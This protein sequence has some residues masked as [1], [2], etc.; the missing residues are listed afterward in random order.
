M[1]KICPYCAHEFDV[2]DEAAERPVECPE[3]GGKVF[4][5][6]QREESFAVENEV[7]PGIKVGQRLGDYEIEGRLGAGGMAVVLRAKQLA[8]NRPVALKILPEHFAENPVFVSRF[9]AEAAVL[10][11]LDHPNIVGVIDRG[12]QDGNYYIVMSLIEGGSLKERLGERQHLSPHESLRIMEQVC[13]GL[14]YAHGKGVIHRDIKP[15][16]IM[17]SPDGRVRIA[18]FGLAHLAAEEGGMDLT[19]S[20]QAMG[21][22]KYMAP[23]QLTDPKTVDARADIYAMGVTLYEMLTGLAPMGAFRMPSEV[24]PNIDVRL[25]DTITKAMQTDPAG[26]FQTVPE[27]LADLKAISS[28]A[29]VTAEQAEQEEVAAA[30]SAISVLLACRA[31]G[32]E[33]RPEAHACEKCGADLSDLFEP[34]HECGMENRLDVPNCR[35]CGTDLGLRRAQKRGRTE[36]RQLRAMQLRKE[37]KYDEAIGVLE[38]IVATRGREYEQVRES[39]QKWIEK[40]AANRDR[41]YE[42]VYNAGERFVAEGRRHH[43][44]RLWEQLP[45]DYRDVR[46]RIEEVRAEVEHA[47][48][49]AREGSELS[50]KGDWQA[51]L[52]RWQEAARLMPLDESLRNRIRETKNR[53]GNRALIREFMKE[54]DRCQSH[55]NMSEALALCQRVLELDP[56]HAGAREMVEELRARRDESTDVA[57]DTGLVIQPPV[58]FEPREPA[59]APVKLFL[60]IAGIGILGLVMLL[61]FG[62]VGGSREEDAAAKEQYARAEQLRDEGNYTA[63]VAQYARVTSKHAGSRWAEMAEVEI[64]DL[65]DRLRRANSLCRK[66]ESAL[67]NGEPEE[68]IKAYAQV[69]ADPKLR[70]DPAIR[71]RAESGRAKARKTA[72]EFLIG[73][74]KAAE[75][76]GEWKK[77]LG[78]YKDADDRYGIAKQKHIAAAI[79][80]AEKQT[81]LLAQALEAMKKAQEK[82]EWRAALEAAERA[83]KIS[84]CGRDELLERMHAIAGKIEP[85]KDMV[86][87]GRG[88][89]I[90]GADDGDKDEKPKREVLI[91]NL[92]HIDVYEVSNAGYAEFLKATKIKPPPHWRGPTPPKGREQH[93]VVNV[94]WEEARAYARAR[95]KELPTEAQ[96]ERAA[97]G[98]KGRLYSWGEVFDRRR[99]VLGFDS[100]PVGTCG[101]DKSTVGG[102][103]PDSDKACFDM[104][105]NVAEW[106]A[107]A[108]GARRVVKGASWVGLEKGRLTRPVVGGRG[109][110][111]LLDRRR[112]Q[113]AAV[114][115]PRDIRMTLL[116]RSGGLDLANIQVEKWRPRIR[117]WASSKFPVPKGAPIGR[118]KW[119]AKRKVRVEVDFSTGCTFLQFVKQRPLTMRYRDPFGME[120]CMEKARERPRTRRGLP[121]HEGEPPEDREAPVA[122]RELRLAPRGA[123][124]MTG[125]PDRRYLNV[126]FRCVKVIWRAPKPQTP[127]PQTGK[128]AAGPS[129]ANP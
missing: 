94:T 124:R 76:R 52:E 68:A 56:K 121:A 109:V 33:S 86:R 39:A 14:A 26:R 19:R 92:F 84:A 79:A 104:A 105:G 75:K 88:K 55:G 32:H 29:V 62:L 24:D 107:D 114:V 58:A 57:V 100:T 42:H 59:A 23:E 120:W 30:P 112:G 67:E 111:V 117:A 101:S 83:L 118:K 37:K 81:G 38:K 45:P 8:L 78:H 122:K 71:E 89:F 77:A 91:E 125:R 66:G 4:A 40:L 63:A 27:M 2:T 96:W 98:V 99:A 69:L 36:S 129:A 108:C 11:T 25:D 10:A 15:G 80:H 93:P 70:A 123:N 13:D 64:H 50:A 35:Q 3:C 95:G 115:C 41:Q 97:R 113:D 6:L 34:C 12:E 17:V 21:T 49:L 127:K 72:I 74:A 54:A 60:V 65:E 116:G 119:V 90:M 103:G 51:A 43:A 7:A 47:R 106:T 28:S 82:Q 128:P 44:T 20:G 87:I 53:L 110:W 126:G 73:Q 46:K 16:N 1:Q 18:D 5:E 22:V 31:C 85:Q 102:D 61:A 9:H 48:D